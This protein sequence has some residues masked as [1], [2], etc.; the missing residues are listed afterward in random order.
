MPQPFKRREGQ[1]V[2]VSPGSIIAR[3]GLAI[4]I[5]LVASHWAKLE[6]TLS[7]GFTVLLGGQEPSAFEA[8][9]E[10]FE[11]NLRHKMFLAAARRR[12]LPNELIVEAEKIHKEARKI[13]TARNAVVHGSWGV[14]DD[15]PD[16][17]L[18]CDAT[19]MNKRVDQF[20][21]DF[22]D[23]VDS[24]TENPLTLTWSFNLGVDDYIEYKHQD[25]QDIIDRMSTLD[26]RGYVFWRK[27]A[28][29]ALSDV[30]ERRR[31]RRQR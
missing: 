26:S 31:R 16:S 28:T 14:C 30:L 27:V 29:F 17:L 20:L 23:K 6:H 11:L 2:N 13:A 25:F 10:L 5:S 18:L 7:L 4:G 3:P 12:N 15:R 8:Y 21:E 9:H 1:Q 19:D 24:N 22:H